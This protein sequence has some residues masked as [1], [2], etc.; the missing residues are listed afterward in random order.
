MNADEVNV[1]LE[2]IDQFISAVNELLG[3]EIPNDL[4]DIDPIVI[5]N[6][7]SYFTNLET[8]L[9]IWY[10]RCHSGKKNVLL[11]ARH[12]ELVA[13]ERFLYEAIRACRD[14]RESASR[15]YT[16]YEKYSGITT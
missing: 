5:V 4:G 7:I 15:L 3:A 14:K 2:E 8:M 12:S 13:K 6:L 16:I 1:Q 11:K 9:V 10:G